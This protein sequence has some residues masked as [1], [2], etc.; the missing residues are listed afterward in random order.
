MFV[1]MGMALLH[2][3]SYVEKFDPREHSWTKLPDMNVKRGCHS[4]VVLNEKL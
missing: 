2:N 4:L 3:C 1:L